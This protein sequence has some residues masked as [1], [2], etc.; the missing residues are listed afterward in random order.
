MIQGIIDL[1][2]YYG[3]MWSCS[4]R[5]PYLIADFKR[6]VSFVGH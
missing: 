5:A 2:Y 1:L 4:L 6:E 3:N